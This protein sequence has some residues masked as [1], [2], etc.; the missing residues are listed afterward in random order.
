MF[1]M[2]TPTSL[3]FRWSKFMLKGMKDFLSIWENNAGTKGNSIQN[4]MD[5]RVT[6]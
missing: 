5:W 3:E 4:S 6:K 1:P 2:A